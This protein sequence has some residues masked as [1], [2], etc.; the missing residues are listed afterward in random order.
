M[1]PE[2][3]LALL[4]QAV[5][6]GGAA[7]MAFFGREPRA[8]DK[9]D[10][11]GPV[12]EADLAVDALL[13]RMLRQARPDYGWL[14]E[15]TPD[16]PDRLG[17]PRIFVVDPIDG[18]RAFMAGERGWCVAAATV[19]RGAVTAAA[20]WFPARDELYAA[21]LGGGASLNGAALRP[22]VRDRLDGAT[23][24]AGAPQLEA[25]H[26]PGGAPPVRRLFR[27]SLVHRF[28]LV[29]AGRADA[30]LT[31]RPAWEWDV[32]A[33]ALIAAEAGCVVTDGDGGTLRFNAPGGRAPGLLAAPPV[34]HAA[35]LSR[36]SIAR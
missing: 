13:K 32:A 31:F 34:L 28:C 10:A 17:R 4:T 36:R 26:W 23:V 11:A 33:G 1:S 21:S 20:A 8:W 27:S 24:L 29:A 15:E 22:S 12:T 2:A 9:P 3:D 18:T 25:R 16:D 19:D 5:R 35:L 7:A 6:A 30:T 14:S